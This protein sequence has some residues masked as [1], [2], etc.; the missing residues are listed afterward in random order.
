MAEAGAESTGLGYSR[1]SMYNVNYTEILENGKIRVAD[2]T[3]PIEKCQY[4]WEYNF[5]DVPYET[6]STEVLRSF[7]YSIPTFTAA[8]IIIIIIT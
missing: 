8:I 5:T 1:C 3:W 4:G 2:P 6:V 7:A